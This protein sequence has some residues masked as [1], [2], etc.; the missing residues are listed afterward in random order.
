LVLASREIDAPVAKGPEL[1]KGAR[2]KVV[3][4]DGALLK[5]VPADGAAAA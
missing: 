3:G 5:V 4:V 1:P 2:I